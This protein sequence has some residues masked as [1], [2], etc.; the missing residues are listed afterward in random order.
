MDGSEDFAVYVLA[1]RKSR[2]VQ[3]CLNTVRRPGMIHFYV[4]TILL[5]Q[6]M[7]A[8]AVVMMHRKMLLVALVAIAYSSVITAT[9]MPKIH[10]DLFVALEG[11]GTAFTAGLSVI[12]GRERAMTGRNLLLYLGIPILLIAGGSVCIHISVSKH[13]TNIQ[14]LDPVMSPSLAVVASAATAATF[15]TRSTWPRLAILGCGATAVMLIQSVTVFKNWLTTP[16]EFAFIA[17]WCAVDFR[18]KAYSLSKNTPCNH[19][20]LVFVAVQLVSAV[21]LAPRLYGDPVVRGWLQGA[22]YFLTV[23]GVGVISSVLGKRG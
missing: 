2:A 3:H 8:S 6:S 16:L 12:T 15:D 7:Q 14:T 23:S 13:T 21:V 4:A 10:A 11:M 22:G 1:T 20:P 9:C 18:I 19:T 5:M 17:F